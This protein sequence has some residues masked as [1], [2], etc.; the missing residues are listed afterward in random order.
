MAQS[1]GEMMNALVDDIT[2][3]AVRSANL[4][5]EDRVLAGERVRQAIRRDALG[6]HGDVVAASHGDADR[7]EAEAEAFEGYV[8]GDRQYRVEQ[9]AESPARQL[10]AE[11]VASDDRI[12]KMD[13]ARTARAQEYI[14]HAAA[15]AA[16]AEAGKVSGG[17]SQAPAAARGAA[18]AGPTAVPVAAVK[19]GHV[20][21]PRSANGRGGP[22]IG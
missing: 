7:P 20:A 4:S 10:A 13:P 12:N 19:A 21:K 6:A 9:D 16:Q 15:F 17:P 5:P 8:H 2:R 18:A 1:R 3:A 14:A 22:S 11:L